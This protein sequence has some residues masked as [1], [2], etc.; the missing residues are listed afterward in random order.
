MF[1]PEL[2]I[3]LFIWLYYRTISPLLQG[4]RPRIMKVYR[5]HKQILVPVQKNSAKNVVVCLRGEKSI[6][7]SVRKFFGFHVDKVKFASYWWEPYLLEIKIYQ[8]PD[9]SIFITY[10]RDELL[11]WAKAHRHSVRRSY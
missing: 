5:V 1:E 6:W 4:K 3:F 11:D 7:L 9:T 2:F 10:Y 8:L